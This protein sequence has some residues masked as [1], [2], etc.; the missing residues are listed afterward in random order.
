[1]SSVSKEVGR[2]AETMPRRSAEALLEF[3]R[4]LAAYSAAAK[5]RAKEAGRPVA[6]DYAAAETALVTA[7]RI[8]APLAGEAGGGPEGIAGSLSSLVGRLLTIADRI[9]DRIWD[10]AFLGTRESKKFGKL[11][12]EAL[13]EFRA[14]K[15]RPLD[16][17]KM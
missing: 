9:E 4:V 2:L 3:A 15:T 17:G 8:L 5:E 10:Q 14:G 11:A 13:A 7:S 1:M 16:P 12:K 6:E